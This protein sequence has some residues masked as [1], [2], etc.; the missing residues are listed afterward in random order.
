MTS[1]P[2]SSLGDVVLSDGTTVVT[3]GDYTLAQI[4]GM[5]FLA[6]P[7]VFGGPETFSFAVTDNGTTNGVADFKTLNQSLVINVIEAIPDPIIVDVQVATSSD[8]A[9]EKSSGGIRLTSSDL[10]LIQDKSN[11]QVVGLR[12]TG[13]N[14]PP[15]AS[16]QNAY[17]QFQVDEVSSDPTS[18]TIFGEAVDNATTFTETNGNITSRPTTSASVAWSPM[19]WTTV[20][21]AGPDEQTSDIAA[22][23]QEIVNRP[24]WSSSNA[25]AIIITGTGGRVAEAFDGVSSAAARLHVEY[26]PG[27]LSEV[28]STPVL[29]SGAVDNLTVVKNSPAT[30]LGLA[31]LGYG[32]GGGA[33]ENGQTLSYSVTS[34]PSPS[35]GDV[36]LSDG[37]TVVTPGDY[38]L[39]QIQGMQFRAVPGVFGGPETFSFAVTDDG[40]TNGVADFKTLNQSLVI[41]VIEAIPD[42]IIVD[43]QVATSSDD[44]EERSTGGIRLTSSDLELIQDKSVQQVVGLRFTGV[45]IPPGASIQNAYIQF[46]ADEVSSDPTSLT[47]FG[48]AVDNATTFTS[49]NG[50]ITSRPTTS[51]SVAWSP[52][53][54]TT[55]GQA[56]PDEQTSDIAAVIQE[57]V[58]R[59]GWSSSN[60]LAIIITGTGG[61]VAEAFDGVP[62][63]A[64]RLHVEYLP[65]NLAPTTSG[66]ADLNVNT[67]AIG[68]INLFAAFDDFE[69]PDPALTYSIE[70]NTN[71]SLFT[72][73]AIDDRRVCTGCCQWKWIFKYPQQMIPQDRFP[74]AVKCHKL[75]NS[76][77]NLVIPLTKSTVGGGTNR[78][79]ES[80]TNSST[81]C[82]FARLLRR[83]FF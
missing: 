67:D 51:A 68:V 12:F 25:L 74:D 16:I 65:A 28:N 13:V 29:S 41:N 54:W 57:I 20:G 3:P 45:N 26:L 66:I 15:G 81:L 2:S 72:S 43:V 1:V 60:A 9:E 44:A 8:D 61:R 55:V 50:N 49:T 69:D 17:I 33:D 64:A 38:T 24:G 7:G 52:M 27:N 47:I 34:V 36:V 39:A 63:A 37:T 46:Q 80:L 78:P 71:S 77:T 31:G 19:P 30:S 53:P 70:N 48:E 35:L 75:T 62:S 79:S 21:Q 58:N 76:T 14:I 42:P 40:T 83:S 23:I 5:Q 73:T 82:E 11:Q 4:Q 6:A 22:V 18:L 56:G 32:A 59:P 10:E